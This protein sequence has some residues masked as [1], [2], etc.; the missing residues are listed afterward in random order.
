MP[1]KTTNNL[2]DLKKKVWQLSKNTISN[3][4]DNVHIGGDETIIGQKTFNEDTYMKKNLQI[5]GNLTDG[6]NSVSVSQIA[7]IDGNYP[8]MKVGQATSA[9]TANKAT[10]ASSASYSTSTNMANHV[11]AINSST[12]AYRPIWFSNY[13][14]PVID[15]TTPNFNLS[16]LCNPAK[17]RIRFSSGG[18][19]GLE[20]TKNS[21]AT[22]FIGYCTGSSDGT[23]VIGS[24]SGTTYPTGLAIG[25]TSGNLLWKGV[26]VATIAQTDLGIGTTGT[27]LTSYYATWKIQIGN[28]KIIGGATPASEGN[29]T[30][31]FRMNNSTSTNVFS[32]KIYGLYCSGRGRTSYTGNGWQYVNATNISTGSILQISSGS[33]WFAIGE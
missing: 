24:I 15:N 8:E 28:I 22:P 5:D 27:S 33:Y 21:Y 6:N 25:G 32:S 2:E 26:K 17:G 13:E 31:Y 30:I 7:H 19:N 1:I 29:K 16:L 9:T 11:T 10:S 20:W 23:F 18:G 12:D 14:S 4:E 3:A